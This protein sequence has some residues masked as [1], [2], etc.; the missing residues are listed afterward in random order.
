MS[1]D[2]KSATRRAMILNESARA[3]H[4]SSAR[5]ERDRSHQAGLYDALTELESQKQQ[6]CFTLLF[7]LLRSAENFIGGAVLLYQRFR[8]GLIL[9]VFTSV[10]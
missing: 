7:D 6:S 10:S 5:S 4:G 8:D 2:G 9:T 1:I 3:K